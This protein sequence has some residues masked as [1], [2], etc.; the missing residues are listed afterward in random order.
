MFGGVRVYL[1]E[2]AGQQLRVIHGVFAQV[3]FA[4]ICLLAMMAGR[5]WNSLVDLVT[6]GLLKKLSAAALVLVFVQ[7]AFG[8]LLRHLN[9]PIGQRLHPLLAFAVLALVV[10]TLART[11]LDVEGAGV[12]RGKA[13]ALIGTIG[14]QVL[15]GVEAWLRTSD[16]ASRHQPVGVADAVVRSLHV[17]VGFG[18]VS[19]AT[20]LAARA[21]KAKLI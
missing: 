7:V 1:N 9:D 21:W 2:L 13:V 17:L 16:P 11:L 19:S 18:V 3:V 8:G 12:L 4:G 5:A 6:D 15:L 10:F 14:V 20:L